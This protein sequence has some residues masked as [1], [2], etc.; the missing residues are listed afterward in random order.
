MPPLLRLKCGA[1]A[2]HNEACGGWRGVIGGITL[3]FI[4]LVSGVWVCQ[5]S[6]MILGACKWLLVALRPLLSAS[7]ISK[8]P[9]D[10]KIG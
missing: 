8:E 4:L 5:N 7:A 10:G 2:A 3:L 1:I 6:K 9:L